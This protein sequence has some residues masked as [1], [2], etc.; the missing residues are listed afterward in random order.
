MNS[1]MFLIVTAQKATYINID[2]QNSL[3]VREQY[4]AVCL[5]MQYFMIIH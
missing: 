2:D 5:W 1:H 4:K 3:M